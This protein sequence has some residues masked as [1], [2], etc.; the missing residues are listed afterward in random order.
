MQLLIR[1]LQMEVHVQS[2]DSLTTRCG[3]EPIYTARTHHRRVVVGTD[4]EGQ[5]GLHPLSE[6]RCKTLIFGSR[7]IVDATLRSV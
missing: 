4:V 1:D 7:V 5:R 6:A 3:L 2:S